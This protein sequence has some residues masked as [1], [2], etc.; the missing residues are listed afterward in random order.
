MFLKDKVLWRGFQ[1]NL[2]PGPPN[3]IKRASV[4]LRPWGKDAQAWKL[5]KHSK[6]TRSSEEASRR[7][8]APQ[9]SSILQLYAGKWKIFKNW[10]MSI[11]WDQIF[12]SISFMR[13]SFPSSPLGDT[14][15]L[16]LDPSSCPLASTLVKTQ[17][18]K[19]AFPRERTKAL[20]TFPAWHLSVVLIS[21]V[22]EPFKPLSDI[23][24]KL[25]TFS[26]LAA[27]CRKGQIHALSYST[28]THSPNWINVVIHP[29]Q[30]R[31]KGASTLEPITISSRGHT[32]GRD[33]AE[34]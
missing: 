11:D 22:K 13:G 25:L 9:A 8:M 5:S 16:S 4:P 31:T 15:Q 14:G 10:C 21:L 34:D 3:S 23:S 32:L 29:A 20:Q 18:F 1:E 26:L 17:C 6:R 19:T 28:L 2:L 7:I 30:L 33:L 27:G 24:L 12:C